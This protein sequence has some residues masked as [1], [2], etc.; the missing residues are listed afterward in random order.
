MGCIYLCKICFECKKILPIIAYHKDKGKKFDVHHKCK[1]CRHNN[2]KNKCAKNNI[3]SKPRCEECIGK[4]VKEKR[5]I[6][7]AR[8]RERHPE[9]R[10]NEKQK[11]RMRENRGE[12]TNEQW[13]EMMIFFDW[14]CAYSGECLGKERTVDHIIPLSKGERNE[15]Y[16][17]VPMKYI[18][19]CNK[20][21]KSMIE[22]YSKQNFFSKERLDKIH[23]WQKYAYEKWFK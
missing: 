2:Y 14:K 10:F 17:C 15:I 3:K 18:Y 16:N 20:Y 6:Y 8:W 22:W 4:S 11:R 21:N 7:Q 12:I 9:N 23:A 19:N 1:K 13:L 5:R